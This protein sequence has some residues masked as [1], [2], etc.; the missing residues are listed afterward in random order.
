MRHS[1]CLAVI[2]LLLALLAAQAA[3]CDGWETA[4]IA[5]SGADLASTEYFLKHTDL[6]EANPLAPE[7]LWG[8]SVMKVASTAALVYVYRFLKN[9]N[10]LVS[11][12]FAIVSIAAF[13]VATVWNVS[14]IRGSQ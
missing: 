10:P 11:R 1:L 14:L 13:S 6:H 2:F 7:S 9:R 12:W 5:T 3:Y 8:R 4:I